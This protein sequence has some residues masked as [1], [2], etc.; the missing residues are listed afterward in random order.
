MLDYNQRKPKIG[1][2]FLAYEEMKLTNE[3]QTEYCE[4]KGHALELLWK[5]TNEFVLVGIF[6]N[7]FRCWWVV[8]EEKKF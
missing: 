7:I 1:W 6:G 8:N 3:S 5:K 2:L 4:P